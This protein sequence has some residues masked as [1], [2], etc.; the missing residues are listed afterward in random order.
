MTVI[1]GIRNVHKNGFKIVGTDDGREA[2][3]LEL[4]NHRFFIATLFVPQDNSSRENPHK[5]VTKFLEC[6]LNHNL[7]LYF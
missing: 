7:N 6:V 2:R 5:L 4:A 3:I 1:F